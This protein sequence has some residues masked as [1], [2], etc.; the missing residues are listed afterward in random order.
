MSLPVSWKLQ[1]EGA[2]FPFI[3]QEGSRIMIA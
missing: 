1:T 3:E 2:K